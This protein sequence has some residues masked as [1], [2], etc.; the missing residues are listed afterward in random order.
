[1]KTAKAEKQLYLL[2]DVIIFIGLAGLIILMMQAQSFELLAYEMMAFSVSVTAVTLAALGAI[3]NI[4]QRRVMQKIA[5]ETHEAIAELKDLH[6]DN[7]E[8]LRALQ[9]DPSLVVHEIAEVLA[10]MNVEH[11]D[12]KRHAMAGNIEQKVRRRVKQKR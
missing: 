12:T 7:A 3:N 10:E 5:K 6:K 2:L 9:E 1:M 4:Q 8:I 11:D